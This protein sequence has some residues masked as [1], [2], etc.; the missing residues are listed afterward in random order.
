MIEYKNDKER[1][2]LCSFAAKF[3]DHDALAILEKGY[4]TNKED[5]KTLAKLYWRMVDE[6][7]GENMD[8]WLERIYT[9]SHIHMGNSGFDE[10]WEK[11]IP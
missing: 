10:E 4:V 9:T 6:A 8:Y 7:T 11:Q 1:D 2:I 5:V 3:N